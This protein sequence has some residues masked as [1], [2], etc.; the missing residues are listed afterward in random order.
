[1][2]L[3]HR[4]AAVAGLAVAI[5]VVAAAGVI[6]VAVRSELRGEIDRAL[7][8]R[9]DALIAEAPPRAD[10][11]GAVDPDR[12]REGQ[13]EYR[14]DDLRPTERPGSFGG[15]GSYA[16]YVAPDGDVV[17]QPGS[18]ATLPVSARVAAIA[19][20]GRG[21]TLGDTRVKGTHLRVLTV[22]TPRGGAIQVARPLTEVD[23]E[24]DRVLVVLALV[25]AG[26]V[27]LAAGLGAL[28]ARTALSPIARFTQR[29]EAL[30]AEGADISQ[31]MDVIGSDELARLAHSFNATLDALERSVEAQRHLVADASHE[32]RTP[33][34]SLRAN[35]QTL[36][37]ADRLPPEE[38]TSLRADIVEELDELTALVG[39]VV[40]LARGAKPSDALDDVRLD[41]IVAALV[42]RA[43]ARAGTDVRFELRLEPCV[44][45]GEPDRISRAVTNLLDNA[46]KWSPAGGAVEV[47]LQD[48]TLTVRDHG[49]GF[50]PEDLPHVFERF[51]RADGARGMPGSGLGLAIVRQAAE[52]HGGW[53]EAR[54][55]PG[56]GALLRVRFSPEEPA[57]APASVPE[58]APGPARV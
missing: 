21:R 55:A 24:L 13:L 41:E 22:A 42:G 16:Q 51:Y 43:A 48:G 8:S 37:E 6:Y 57:P 5:A 29:T 30:S 45:A 26:G 12:G 39:D 10:G 18:S 15:A 28:V 23:H 11:A 36:E 50:V 35:I 58:R 2:T 1:M 47:G 33:I 7:R 20:S 40:E 9:A 27:M 14:S 56:G 3:R 31:R 53:V 4:I 32:L 46:R 38:L 54:N 34:A 25:G 19:R 49:P 52:A 17:P 44:I